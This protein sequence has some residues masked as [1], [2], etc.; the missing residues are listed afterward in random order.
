MSSHHYNIKGRVIKNDNSGIENARV[1]IW[2]KELLRTGFI[3]ST[4]TNSNGDFE[5]ICE[6]ATI[7]DVF[8]KRY[9]DLFFK[10]YQ[11]V[12]QEDKMLLTTE[13]NP[14]QNVQDNNYEGLMLTVEDSSSITERTAKTEVTAAVTKDAQ[15]YIVSGKVL[16][17]WNEGIDGKTVMAYDNDH[18]QDV[19]LGKATTNADGFYAISY[20]P[21]Q[22]AAEGKKIID[23]I[24]LAFDTTGKTIATSEI[25]AAGRL[26]QNETIDLRILKQSNP[27]P[28]TYNVSGKVASNVSAGIGNLK[29][30][31]VDKGV[32][33]DVQL[34]TTN[35]DVQGNYNISFTDEEI[36]ARNKTQPDLQTKVFAG[37]SLLASS[38]VHYN[39]TKQE[40]LNVL[41]PD[42]VLSSLQSEYDT[43]HGA[44][45]AQYT[46]KLGDLKESDG[47]QD[48][49]YLANKT[50]WDA[51]AIAMAA[52]AD[53][54]S[55]LSK[56]PS[57]NITIPQPFFYA[58]FRAGLP[59]DEN[60]L[61]HTDAATLQNVWKQ[62]ITQ[63][64]I[65]ANSADQ[66]PA[67]V[68]QF[69][70][71]SVNKMLSDPPRVGISTL[72]DLLAV[73]NI[74]DV[75]KQQ[76][77]ATLY[78]AN[79]TDM[80]AFWD[81]ITDT[82]GQDVTNRLQLDSKLAYLTIN[83][84]PLMNAIHE[85]SPQGD[86]SDS[87]QLA[88]LGYHSPDKWNLI[89][90]VT[91]D[92]IPKEIT[93]D[94]PEARRA[95]YASQL[96]GQVRLSYPTA[97][98]AE[99]IKS[100]VISVTPNDDK[101]AANQAYTFLSKNQGKFELGVNTIDQY[102]KDNPSENNIS[103]EGI[104]AIKRLHRTY[105]LTTGDQAFI[106]LL[107]QNLDSAYKIVQYERGN[108]IQSFSKGLGGADVAGQIY[109]RAVQIHTAMLSIS[110]SYVNAQTVPAIGVHSPANVLNPVPSNTGDIAAFSTL[111]KI[112]SSMDYSTCSDCNSI[113]SP[114]AYLVNLLQFIDIPGANPKNPLDELF[115]RRPDINHLLLTCENTNT[116]LPYIDIVNE[117]LEYYVT[118]ELTLNRNPIMDKNGN[119]IKDDNGNTIYTIEYL[120]HDTNEIA[121]EDLLANPQYVIDTAYEILKSE[122]FPLVLPFHQPL[123]FLRRYFNT[124]EVPLPAAMECLRNTDDLEQGTNIFGW[125][126]IWMEQI[127]VSRSEN[128][129]LTNSTQVPLWAMYGFPG[130]STKMPDDLNTTARSDL[131]N[132]KQFAF[133]LGITYDELFSLLK[134]RFINPYS[135]L[136]PKL[137]KLG[138]TFNDLKELNDKHYS[139]ASTEDFTAKLPQGLNAPDPKEYNPDIVTWVKNGYS[140]I[141]GLITLA[142]PVSPWTHKGYKVGECVVP[143]NRNKNPQQPIPSS[144]YYVCTTAGTSGGGEPDWPTSPQ[145]NIIDNTVTWACLDVAS[146]ASF[147][148]L[149][150]RY[151]D[152]A[153]INQDISGIDFIKML[154]FIRL[155]KRLDWTIDQTD[156]AICALWPTNQDSFN[157]LDISQLDKGF[158][159]LMPQLGIVSRAIKLLSLNVDRE[160]YSLLACWSDIGTHG[161]TSLYRQMFLNPAILSQDNIF[162]D[163]GYGD[164]LTDNSQT[165]MDTGSTQKAIINGTATVGDV[166]N[167]TINGVLIQSEIL[168]LTSDIPTK[169]VADIKANTTIDPITQ[170]PLNTIITASKYHKYHHN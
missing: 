15:T 25:I 55:T 111:E 26:Q 91:N 110:L 163:K 32:G 135:D 24:V 78:A 115:E 10:V 140:K 152:P 136:I 6:V 170:L 114:S 112:F 33:G 13:D 149:K 116:A 63:N 96:A 118:N 86:L 50:G 159:S 121:S 7:A 85:L 103:T 60:L 87:L 101:N 43:L 132:A 73:S 166:L 161:T 156:E 100:H 1:E 53:Q 109:D 61:F 144:L 8:H 82:F 36:I 99:M 62:A 27:N 47:Q 18:I 150:F 68:Q 83:N 93:G 3:K 69:Q 108:F 142:I 102:I 20:N 123:E 131:S 133:R 12:N 130:D 106:N 41:L 4:Y 57:D 155:Y 158:C 129:I 37:N 35:T 77:V 72:K 38:D 94:T 151:S 98:V 137:E 29:V 64:V 153:K 165:I 65:P 84:A 90:K 2:Q 95:N 89:L 19:S 48:I 31:I 42:A 74:T 23:L 34:A 162:S 67:I 70:A 81:S 124:L 148:N 21:G 145:P 167:T 80:P 169:V 28:V 125:R 52:L 120:G 139:Q 164:F 17:G 56:D 45:G 40:V 30:V 160:L 59:S 51:R 154:R 9:P 88:Q 157:T 119:E 75:K 138:V 127:K 134:T 11:Q 92:Q 76:Q 71:I 147:G 143:I 122:Y 97:S 16:N 14:W 5:L 105:Q 22:F 58:L 141:M 107:D 39:A 126:D 66:I 79:R 113:L 128:D 104:A 44:I 168:D 54:F 117:T 46:G 146:T 49:S